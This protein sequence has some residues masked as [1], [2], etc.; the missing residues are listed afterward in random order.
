VAGLPQPEQPF[1]LYLHS[2]DISDKGLKELAGLKN[3]QGLD[4]GVTK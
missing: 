3:L 1:A 2:T 4:L